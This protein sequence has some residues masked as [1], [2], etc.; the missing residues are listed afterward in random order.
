MRRESFIEPAEPRGGRC[1]DCCELRRNR[2][3]IEWQSCE[4][5]NRTIDPARPSGRPRRGCSGSAHD[6]PS[7][8]AR[9][10]AAIACSIIS[11]RS[12]GQPKVAV[13]KRVSPMER[14]RSLNQL[15]GAVRVAGL[16]LDDAEHVKGIGLIGLL[17]KDLLIESSPPARAGRPDDARSPEGRLVAESSGGADK[18]KHVCPTIQKMRRAPP[19]A[20]LI[21]LSDVRLFAFAKRRNRLAAG[22]TRLHLVP[23]ADVFLAQLPAEADIVPLVAA[24]EVDQAR[25]VVFQLAADL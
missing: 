8:P 4:R 15:N 2:G 12:E 18:N 19:A 14:E 9:S 16:M 6:L 7:A 23:V 10:K 3:A 24:G 22:E 11:K 5:G 1:R 21:G 13:G 25:L 17:R 20:F